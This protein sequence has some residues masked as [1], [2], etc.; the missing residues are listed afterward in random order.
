MDRTKSYLLFIGVAYLTMALAAITIDLPKGLIS[1]V[2]LSALLF[3]LSEALEKINDGKKEKR[4]FIRILK[5]DSCIDKYGMA[6]EYINEV[7]NEKK[8][9]LKLKRT[10][11]FRVSVLLKTL[12][13]MC[14]IVYPYTVFTYISEKVNNKFNV[15]CTIMSLGLMFF[16]FYI[17]DFIYSKNEYRDEDEIRDCF[18]IALDESNT[19][20][21]RCISIAEKTMASRKK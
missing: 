17:D 7:N 19:L 12:A 1:G 2:S 9:E 8:D 16:S 4:S 18:D 21:E 15:F 10:I 6:L 11:F 20:N 13:F 14:I 5:N 3:S